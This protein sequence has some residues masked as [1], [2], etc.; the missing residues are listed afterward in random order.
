MQGRNILYIIGQKGYPD[1]KIKYRI[2]TVIIV[3]VICI[4]VIC[5]YLLSY[6]KIGNIYSEQTREVIFDLRKSFLKDT[7]NNL[8]YEI[9]AKRETK[10]EHYKRIVDRRQKILEEKVY[11]SDDEFVEFFINQCTNESNPDL[12]TAFIWNNKDNKAVYDPK[13]LYKDKF[14]TTLETLKDRLSS[15]GVIN[16]G[17]ITGIFGVSK[18]YID[19]SVKSEIIEK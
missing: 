11:L 7:V 5:S 17:Y 19:E 16:H 6:E 18:N 3:V 14:N 15:Y 9:E 13:N 12:W 2:T 8:I 1:M 10:A 4:V